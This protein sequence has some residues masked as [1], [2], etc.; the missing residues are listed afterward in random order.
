MSSAP[1]RTSST[2]SSATPLRRSS[3]PTTRTGRSS[4][5]WVR[6]A[7]W[8]QA[9]SIALPLRCARMQVSGV[10]DAPTAGRAGRPPA[11][12]H[13]RWPSLKR[14]RACLAACRRTTPSSCKCADNRVSRAAAR[15]AAAALPVSAEAPAPRRAVRQRVVALARRCPCT[16]SRCRPT[17]NWCSQGCPPRLLPSHTPAR[18]LR[19][20]SATRTV[21]SLSLSRT[22]PQTW[23]MRMMETTRSFQRSAPLGWRLQVRRM[24]IAS[25]S[26][27]PWASG[28]SVWLMATRTEKSPASSHSRWPSRRTQASWMSS[29]ATPTT[30]SSA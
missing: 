21:S 20:T 13:S 19:S 1:L 6:P 5:T 25:P 26:A 9:R 7:K 15:A 29:P 11:R 17:R 2:T 14:A 10:S 18:H 28:V 23:C 16:S 4:P 22:S 30:P 8:P 12:L 24:A 3:S 27:S